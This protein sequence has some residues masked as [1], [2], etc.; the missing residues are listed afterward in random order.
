MNLD[1]RTFLRGAALGATGA[2]LTSMG[3]APGEEAGTST[4]PEE[5]SPAPSAPRFQ[6]SLAQWS[7]HR[8]Y[9]GKA[10]DGGY[11]PLFQTLLANPRGVLQGERQP[12]E[13]ATMARELGVSAV[14]YVNTFFF[15]RAQ[16]ATFVAELKARADAEGVESL[17]IMCDA[18]G[19]LGDPDGAQRAAAVENHRKWLEC[20]AEL[21]CR[22]IRVNAASSGSYEEQQQLAA[23]GLRSVCEI[24][25]PMGLD[26]LV[27]NHGG[28]SSNGAWLAEVLRQVDH[29]RMGSLPD[30]GNFTVSEEETYDR[31]L[32]VEQLM[33]L[34]RAVSA[35]S[36]DFDESGNET[37]ID[38]DRMMAIVLDA[39]YGGFVGIEYEGA[40]LPEPEGIEATRRLLER[41]RA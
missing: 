2:S 13:F 37:T 28:L 18:E 1:R 7:L 38:Y 3:C 35:K 5:A 36:Y 30:F 24:A 25:D 39:G 21:G 17:L 6:I 14:E 9:F 29:P 8:T 27:E 4:G 20:A 31:Y 26:V 10:L 22:A 41:F 12:V 11:T 32:G 19:S 40:R 15:D 16:D 23:D 33:P 34:A